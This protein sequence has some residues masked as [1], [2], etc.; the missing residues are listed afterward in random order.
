MRDARCADASRCGIPKRSWRGVH[1]I[2]AG[3]FGRNPNAFELFQRRL[4]STVQIPVL[5]PAGDI[6]SRV[7]RFRAIKA[8]STDEFHRARGKRLFGYR[9]CEAIHIRL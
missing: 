4:V 6:V 1:W 9:R 5:V 3:Y 2:A 7:A 8:A